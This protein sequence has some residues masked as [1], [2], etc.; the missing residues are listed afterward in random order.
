MTAMLTS[1][2]TGSASQDPAASRPQ[3]AGALARETVADPQAP[4]AGDP[5]APAAAAPRVEV[6]RFADV[7]LLRYQVPGFAELD[8]RHKELLYYLYEAALSGREI[9][10]DQK[11]RY[12]LG[13]KRTLEEVVKGYSGDRDA[14]DFQALALYLKRIWFANGI[15][16]HYS[17]DKFAPGFDFGALERMVDA[18]P[19]GR[20]PVRPGQ[21]VKE[22]LAELKPVIFDPAVDAKLVSKSAA[23]DVVASSAINFYGRGLTQSQVAAFYAG[24]LAPNDPAPVSLGLNSTLELSAAGP[25]ERVWKVGGRYTEALEQVVGW[26]EKACTVAESDAQRAAL[27]KLVRFY[28]SGELGDWDDYNIAWI[29]DKDSLVDVINGFIEVYHDPLGM[30]GSFESVV[31]FRDAAATKRIDAIAREAQW[32]EDHS[33]ILDRHKK[34]DVKGITGRVITVV[35]EAGDTSPATPIGINLP[36]ADWIRTRHGSK[37]VS[38]GNIVA[39]YDAV[40]GGADREFAWDAAD[41]ERGARYAALASELN[42]DMHEVIGHASGQIDPGVAPIH[43]TLKTYGSTLEEA[44]ADLVALYYAID[45]KLVEL[46]LMP[47]IEVGQVQYER[48]IRNGLQLQLYR[49]PAGGDIEEDHMRNRQLVAAWCYEKGERDNVIERRERDGKTYLVV[50]DF[51]RLRELF[52]ELLRELQRIKSEGDYEAGRDLVERYA[53]KVDRRMHAEVLERYAKL[54]IPP[55]AGFMGPRLVPVRE[56]ER[57]VDVKLEYPEDFGAQMLEYASRYA[58][59]PTWN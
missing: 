38:L 32:F 34:A 26:L 50:N 40:R 49:V 8:R 33:P 54:D 30:R 36:N 21:S 10:F 5:Q 37:S 13:V 42:T 14:P 39:A 6:E 25:V 3:R 24:R 56:G 7:R 12:N 45:P 16:H 1:T 9:I 52:G 11:Y 23:S 27:E 15:H 28:R 51:V 31:S 48:Y 59:L 57:V 46:G 35:I 17:N 41:A 2:S 55:F 58:F 4:A 18:T 22:L 19:L 43:E 47:L 20:F 44:R 53:V 29:A